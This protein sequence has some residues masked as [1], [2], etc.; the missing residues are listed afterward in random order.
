[1]IGERLT[2]YSMMCPMR[3][4]HDVFLIIIIGTYKGK[5]LSTILHLYN[6]IVQINVSKSGPLRIFEIWIFNPCHNQ[7]QSPK[8]P[9]KYAH[10]YRCL[11]HHQ[12]CMITMHI[13]TKWVS[14]CADT[15]TICL[16]MYSIST[17]SGTIK[18]IGM[19]PGNET[20]FSYTPEY[21]TN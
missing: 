21:S 12:Y 16:Q 2:K 9:T 13:I 18:F 11:E 14:S 5:L 6:T 20:S 8:Q 1:M 19:Q 17:S 3:Q 10:T 4:I 15:A 7:L